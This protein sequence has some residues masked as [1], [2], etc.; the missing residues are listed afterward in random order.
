MPKQLD[1]RGEFTWKA[2]KEGVWVEIP[3]P[4]REG[5]MAAAYFLAHRGQ[6]VL[7][8]LRIFPNVGRYPPP[9][10]R[11]A[12]T[13]RI[14]KQT[15]TIGAP[16]VARKGGEWSRKVKDL[17]GAPPGGIPV[18]LLQDVPLRQMIEEV[19][20]RAASTY[21]AK[22]PSGW[23]TAVRNEPQRPG[24]R[25][26]SDHFYAVWAQRYEKRFDAS[27]T[28]PLR[29][30]EREYGVR[31]GTVVGYISEARRR[32]LLWPTTRGKA[33]AALTPK[34]RELLEKG[35]PKRKGRGKG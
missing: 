14:G 17:D 18:R 27:S 35:P 4:R 24:R 33:F 12:Q 25:G 1:P 30:L 26:R 15:W 23:A 10:W 5:W 2:L 9:D 29:D 21:E 6:L 13:V 20:R 22:L 3:V 11:K 34:A 8:E 19:H 28:S 31:Y 7:A 16:Q 32:D